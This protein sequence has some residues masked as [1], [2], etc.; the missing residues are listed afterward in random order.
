MRRRS[1][2]TSDFLLHGLYTLKKRVK[3]SFS[4]RFLFNLDLY[5]LDA[6]GRLAVDN[7]SNLEPVFVFLIKC[8]TS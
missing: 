7:R 2:E 5:E 3:L 1:F 6:I 4:F 8:L